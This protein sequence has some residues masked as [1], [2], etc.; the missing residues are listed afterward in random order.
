MWDSRPRLSSAEGGFNLDL[1][2][3]TA[4]A[5]VPHGNRAVPGDS[6]LQEFKSPRRPGLGALQLDIERM[7][8][9]KI[10]GGA[11][12]MVFLNRESS[13]AALPRREG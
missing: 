1:Q 4:G 11:A 12:E 6:G 7:R 3:N 9:R 13:G 2:S 10:R 8:G 5:A